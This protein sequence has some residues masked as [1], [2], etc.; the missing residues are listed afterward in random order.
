VG[1]DAGEAGFRNALRVLRIRNY[2]VYTIGNA[3]SL[4]GVWIQRIAVGWLAWRLTHSGFW[5]G[6]CAAGDLVPSVLISPFAGALAD[7]V[8]RVRLV[9]ISLIF[10]MIQA[11]ILAILTFAGVIDI[12]MLFGLTVALGTI[13][14][15]NQPARLALI[16]NLVDRGNLGP[17]VAINSLV[18]NN[19]RFIGPATAGFVIAAGNVGLAFTLNAVTYICFIYALLRIDVP[20]D[21]P[22]PEARHFW[23]DLIDGY[24]YALRDPAIGQMFILLIVTTVGIRGFVE[25]FPGFADAVFSR[26]AQGLAWLT[27]MVGLGALVGG[28]LMLRRNTLRGL[29]SVVISSTFWMSLAIIGFTATANYD[30]ALLCAFLS[31]MAMTATGIGAQTLIQSSIA[32]AMR[33]RVMGF[34]GMIFRAGPSLNSLLL[35]AASVHFGLRL[36]VFA[37]A[38][39]CVLAWV[40]IRGSQSAI[41]HSLEAAG[42][43]IA[44]GETAPG[45]SDAA[46]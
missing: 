21:R 24:G 4:V 6:M 45:S 9:Q 1:S 35:G 10:G 13:N 14:A 26:G 5:L 16:P 23:R 41:E 7:R 39:I 17:A 11:W 43:R 30:F 42:R 37:G 29:P 38:C 8:D 27:A 31:G 15:F 28:V 33:G 34:Y 18:F 46:A 25:M 2:R 32:P 20:S 22:P 19:A 12:W 3:I 44:A 36:P 40:W